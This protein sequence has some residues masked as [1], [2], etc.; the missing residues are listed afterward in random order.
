[1]SVMLRDRC[2]D[3]RVPGT[4]QV[5]RHCKWNLAVEYESLFLFSCL[6]YSELT[7]VRNRLVENDDAIS[8]SFPGSSDPQPEWEGTVGA[9]SFIYIFY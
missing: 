9:P 8:N 7:Q 1:M 6:C 4:S 5:L 2:P 3:G